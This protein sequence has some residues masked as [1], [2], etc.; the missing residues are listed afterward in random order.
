L[1]EIELKPLTIFTGAN[2]SGKSNIL[3]AIVILSQIA[4]QAPQELTFP[5]H[6]E[7]GTAEFLRYPYPSIRHLVH[8]GDLESEIE[9]T[10]H[11]ISERSKRPI[12]YGIKFSSEPLS[13]TQTLYVNKNPI[14]R[15]SHTYSKG[16]AFSRFVKPKIW[17]D[18]NSEQNASILLSK[19]VFRPQE[20]ESDKKKIAL[21]KSLRTLAENIVDEIIGELSR[22]YW[23]SAPRGHVPIEIRTGADPLWVGKTGENLIYMLSKIFGQQKYKQLQNEISSWTKKFGIGSIGAGFRKGNLLG[24]DFQDPELNTIIDMISASFGSKQLL[25]IITQILWSKKGDTLLIEEPEISLHPESQV[26]IQELFAE[27]VARGK[28]IICTTHS[29]FFILSL[30]KIIK[31]ELLSKEQIAVYHVEKKEKGTKTTMLRLDDSGFVEGWIPSYL[32]I[33]NRIFEEW[34]EE[35][36]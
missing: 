26:V 15:V 13:S 30:S 23:I 18:K 12:G 22:V 8:K 4:R 14:C 25:T 24:A 1:D 6:L 10:L 29:P 35:L 36:D 33:E 5:K 17:K 16:F 27:A 31:K 20:G 7:V 32:K 28:Q 21:D 19:R 3:E 2:S 34:I 9:I 11:F